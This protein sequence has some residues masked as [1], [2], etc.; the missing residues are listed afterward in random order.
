M[1]NHFQSLQN[2]FHLKSAKTNALRTFLIKP[3]MFL[4][5]FVFT[6]IFPGETAHTEFS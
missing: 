2:V 1:D 6:Y 5:C 3:A 4:V